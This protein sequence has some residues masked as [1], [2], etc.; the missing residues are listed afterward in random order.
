MTRCPINGLIVF[1]DMSLLLYKQPKALDFSGNHLFFQMKGTDYILVHPSTAFLSFLRGNLWKMA[2]GM[3]MYL[4]FMG[5]THCFKFLDETAPAE[6]PVLPVNWIIRFTATTK[7][8][9]LI[10]GLIAY[11]PLGTY[12]AVTLWGDRVIIRANVGSPIYDINYDWAYPLPAFGFEYM[13]NVGIAQVNRPDYHFNCTLFVENMSSQGTYKSLPPFRIDA[14]ENQIAEIDIAGIVRR[15]FLNYFDLPDFSA[16]TPVK[17]QYS[18]LAY[19]MELSEMSSTTVVSTLTTPVFDALNGRVNNS[20]H[21][22]FE[23]KAWTAEKKRF[24]NNMP[25]YMLTYAGSKHHLFYLNAFAGTS[26][27]VVKMTISTTLTADMPYSFT[28]ANLAQYHIVMIP[29]AGILAD[30]VTD[31]TTI[32]QVVCWV[33]DASGTLLAGVQTFVFRQ[34]HIYARSFLFQNPFGMFD[35]IAVQTTKNSLKTEATENTLTLQSGYSRY[36][37]DVVMDLLPGEDNFTAETGP[38]TFDMAAHLKELLAWPRVVFLQAQDRYIRVVI[39]AG[40]TTISDQEKDVCNVSFKYKPAFSG[41]MLSSA[42]ELPK[43]VHRDHSDEY[44][45]TDYQ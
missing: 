14:D 34:K 30:Q 27:I 43:V 16:N 40:S 24:L 20:D 17:T 23:L 7:E 5:V 10:S 9:S 22:T 32:T 41:D 25:A 33:E 13:R 2:S 31:I 3:L 6:E 35:T 45:E 12:Y 21:G 11:P 1:D 37:G 29:I 39:D 19:Y 4:K 42:I 8:E 26:S 36:V 38:I 18:T 28:L 44:I 15:R